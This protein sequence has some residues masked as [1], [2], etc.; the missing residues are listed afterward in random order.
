MSGPPDNI[1]REEALAALED[2]EKGSLRV[3]KAL[4]KQRDIYS[5]EL[6]AGKTVLVAESPF[7]E[8]CANS[9]IEEYQNTLLSEGEDPPSLRVFK[10]GR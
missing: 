1:T 5:K 2:P 6:L 4:G 9:A 7:Q 10:K 3:L 8:V